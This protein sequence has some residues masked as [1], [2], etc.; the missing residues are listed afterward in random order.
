MPPDSIRMVNPPTRAEQALVKKRAGH[1]FDP[2][3]LGGLK[4]RIDEE[5]AEV[6]TT[7][8]ITKFLGTL[9]FD[10]ALDGGSSRTI[11]LDRHGG[12][13]ADCGFKFLHELAEAGPVRMPLRRTRPFVHATRK[14][15]TPP[16][17]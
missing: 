3:P 1:R 9:T 8:T 2:T 7:Q 6:D 10:V 11:R 17:L 15:P 16:L 13:F 4:Q 5:S 12:R 14:S